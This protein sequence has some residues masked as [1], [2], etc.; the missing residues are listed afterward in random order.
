[1]NC[2]TVLTWEAALSV[3]SDRMERPHSWMAR[4]E[5]ALAEGIRFLFW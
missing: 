1:M 4:V 5:T 3:C 2:Q